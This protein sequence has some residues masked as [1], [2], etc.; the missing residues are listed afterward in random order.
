MTLSGSADAR[1]LHNMVVSGE[2]LVTIL[3]EEGRRRRM[4]RMETMIRS[5]VAA[6]ANTS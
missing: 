4:M 6:E 1:F 3:G 5:V 2:L